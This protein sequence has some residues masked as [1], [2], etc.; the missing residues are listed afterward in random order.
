M[1]DL[2]IQL[3]HNGRLLRYRIDTYSILVVAATAPLMIL[4]SLSV[5][6][7]YSVLLTLA[8][9][10][11][12]GLIQHNHCHLS[13]FRTRRV[14][15]LFESVLCF[16]TGI[17]SELYRQQHVNVHHRYTNSPADWTGPFSFEGCSFPDKPAPFW[18]YYVAFVPRAWVNSVGA[19]NEEPQTKRQLIVTIFPAIVLTLALA[20]THP[21]ATAI[22]IGIPWF[23]TVLV[24]PVTNWYHH[25]GCTFETPETSSNV[26]LGF[27]S[28]W[29][30][31]NVG[32]HSAHHSRPAA[33]WSRLPALH[34]RIFPEGLPR[35]R[36]C[37]GITAILASRFSQSAT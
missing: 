18:K 7:F 28:R 29:F 27:F 12:V 1:T 10:R 17:P 37:Y 14:N 22:C 11:W 26:N 2:G 3:S 34:A 16:C 4:G 19:A 32:Y 13:I 31:F 9:L 21:A 24:L 30:G 33:H 25:V 6:P 8:V 15:V 20:A 23:A 5:L 36:V 35:E